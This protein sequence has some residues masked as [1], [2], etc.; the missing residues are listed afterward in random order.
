M[1]FKKKRTK[2]SSRIAAKG[3]S[4]SIIVTAIVLA[5]LV[6]VN[7]LVN[8]LPTATTK[9][10]MTSTNLY[11][12][13]SST[14]AVV[15]ALEK[16]VDIY[17]IVQADQENEVIENL[18][19]KYESLSS[20]I[21]VTKKNPD[22]YPTFASQYTDEDVP[23]NSLIVV[24]G[25][26]SRFISYNDIYLTDVDYSTYS[27]VYSFDG[28]GA[29]T[30]AIDYVISDELPK[31]Y[32]L[33]GHGEEDL[34]TEVSNQIEKENM[35]VET[36]SLVSE[37]EV[38]DD[39]D[40]LLI[41]APE[42]DISEEEAEIIEN[43]IDNGG[44]VLA[45]AGETENGMLTNLSSVLSYYGVETTDGIVVEGD[46]SHYAFQQP[47]ILLP[48]I[49]SN[50]ITDPLIE[51]SYNVIFPIAQGL[52]ITGS[53][54]TSLLTTSDSSFSK[55][56]GFNLTTY[57]KE[58][59]DTDG[60]FSVA[61]SISADNDGQLIWFASNYFLQ[62]TYNAYS[63]GANLDLV[64]NAFSSLIGERD[65]VSIRSKSLSYNYLTIPD[66]TASMLKAWMIGIIPV[67]FV[68]Y[69]IFT[70]IDRRKKRHA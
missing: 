21:T 42:T 7:V 9:Y 13:T 34:P 47:Y 44:K 19:G 22:V 64:M 1:K 25:D 15:N 49:E 28:E 59:G 32:K 5:I 23:N 58:D 8:A 52:K 14:K 31:I 54:A 67:V 38:P 16:D 30:S 33:E 3:G 43:Y 66:S 20:H 68:I 53:K 41:Y 10:D 63:S 26:K 2:I 37:G 11:S 55:A 45:I 18:L 6:A 65:A 29:I 61:V 27:Y 51:S 39:A 50:T 48:T 57:E 46:S 56:A 62:D 60:S 70:V 69:G 24:C 36:L 12:V 17:W 40:V 35:E 4:Y